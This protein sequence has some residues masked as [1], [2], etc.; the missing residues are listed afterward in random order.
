MVFHRHGF[1]S[2]NGSVCT[3]K[4]RTYEVADF[5][6]ACRPYLPRALE[7]GSDFLKS[8]GPLLRVK[9][10]VGPLSVSVLAEAVLL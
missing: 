8:M 7:I 6:C 5:S 1:S 10:A 9:A 4:Q 2:T 3:F